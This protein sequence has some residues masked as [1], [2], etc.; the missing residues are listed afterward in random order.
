[1]LIK[2][3]LGAL[4]TDCAALF[5]NLI[6]SHVCN[7]RVTTYWGIFFPANYGAELSRCAADCNQQTRRQPNTSGDQGSAS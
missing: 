3:D 7:N 6:Y 4:N 1:M 2:A 5:I